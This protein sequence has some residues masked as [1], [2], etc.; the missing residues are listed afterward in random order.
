MSM[1]GQAT[2]ERPAAGKSNRRAVMRAAF[3]ELNAGGF[4]RHD[5]VIQFFLRVRSLIQPDSVVADFGAGRGIAD[6]T[7]SFLRDFAM[8]RGDCARPIGL[9]VDPAVLQNPLMDEAHVIASDGRIPLPDASVDLIYSCATIEHIDDPVRAAQEIGRVLRPGGW[10]CGWTPNK[11]GYVGIAARAVPNRFHSSFVRLLAP[12][13]RQEVDVFPTRYRMNTV[14]AV[15]RAFGPGFQNYS[16]YLAGEPSYSG[17]S[18]LLL[19]LFH[20]YN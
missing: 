3:P 6:R 5:Q 15:S 1:T 4:T 12:G 13:G 8:L 16:H 11:W 14:G 18:K 17:A 10:F 20:T 19:R 2:E 9:D 7:V